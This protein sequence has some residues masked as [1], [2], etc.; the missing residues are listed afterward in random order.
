MTRNRA[1]RRAN[2]KRIIENRLKELKQINPE[3][4]EHIKDNPN[5]VNKKHPLDCGKA[6][7]QICH[8]DDP[9][10]RNKKIDYEE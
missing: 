5:L 6:N 7:C 10:P 4:Y 8:T 1:E 9:T 3:F 2:N